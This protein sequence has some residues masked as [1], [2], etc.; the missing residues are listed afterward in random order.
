V[1]LRDKPALR[2]VVLMEAHL[3]AFLNRLEAVVLELVELA[4]LAA[5]MANHR[6][7]LMVHPHRPMKR[8]NQSKNAQC[9]ANPDHLD[10]TEEWV[11]KVHPDPKALQVPLEPMA[12]EANVVWLVTKL[13]PVHPANKDPKVQ[14][15]MMVNSIIST[16]PPDLKDLRA[17][18]DQKVHLDHQAKMG[19]P[20]PK[21]PMAM[22]AKL[23][24]PDRPPNPADPAHPATK[25]HPVVTEVATIVHHREQ[26]PV[27]KL[28][29]S[30]FLFKIPFVLLFFVTVIVD[31]F[32]PDRKKIFSNII[33][34]HFSRR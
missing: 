21:V 13:V 30:G 16:V 9:N 23:A 29:L 34:C 11:K 31:F 18:M 28:F 32:I 7:K 10:Q 8:K 14:R 33:V 15:E 6:H 26:L 17:K 25:A 24:N 3:L 12:N 5:N 27:I 20:V 2:L 22:W 19:I 1:E 4:V